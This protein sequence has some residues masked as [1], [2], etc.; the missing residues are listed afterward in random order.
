MFETMPEEKFNLWES[1]KM[2]RPR[3]IITHCLPWWWKMKRPAVAD[4][5]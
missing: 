2:K 1:G 5:I 3:T 4:L